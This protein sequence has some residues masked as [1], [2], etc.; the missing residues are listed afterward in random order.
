[1]IPALGFNRDDMIVGG[2]HLSHVFVVRH[3]AYDSHIRRHGLY[4]LIVLLVDGE[5]QLVVLATTQC[6]HRRHNL[7]LLGHAVGSRVD[8]DFL[9]IEL[10][11]HF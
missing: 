8:G 6:R 1:M 10:A 4:L 2:N 9:L 7:E 3:V 5:E 11:A